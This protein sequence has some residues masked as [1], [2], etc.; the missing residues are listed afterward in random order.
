MTR[1]RWASWLLERRS[2]G[3]PHAAERIREYLHPI[4]DAV[5]DAAALGPDTRILD[6]GC[7]DGLI[8]FGAL[9]RGAG[10][11]IFSDVS[12][13]LLDR[14]REMAGDL[15]VLERC[16]FVRVGA[17]DLA[18]LADASV[19]AVTTR[20]VLIYVADKARALREF[21]RVLA[22][23]GRISL[24]EP[25]N[26]YFVD[27]DG[28]FPPTYDSAAVEDL[29][30]RVIAVYRGINPMDG[31]MMSFGERD[32]LEH[33]ERAGF[34]DLHARLDIDVRPPAARD[35][36]SYLASSPNPLAPTLEE[37]LRQTLTPTEIERYARHFRPLVEGGIGTERRAVAYLSAV[38]RGP[39][40]QSPR[41]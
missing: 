10:H 27:A 24:F 4:R 12:Q 38:S 28:R 1:D 19:D 17:E 16:R 25:I 31:P 30:R 33:A 15:D 40:E 39:A 26:R 18:E 14:C 41:S 6:V 13:D 22:P 34:T 8:A 36:A 29:A 5:L 11:V 2:G 7:G 35:W 3:D 21:A 32:L 20:S 9:E 23:G 37:A